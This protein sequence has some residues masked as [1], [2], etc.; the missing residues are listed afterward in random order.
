MKMSNLSIN[1]NAFDFID[2]EAVHFTEQDLTKEQKAQVRKNIDAI[3]MTYSPPANLPSGNWDGFTYGNGM[4]IAVGYKVS[5]GVTGC[6]AYSY[7]G[8][9]WYEAVL[10]RV[11]SSGGLNSVVYA[12]GKFVAVGTM[13]HGAYSIDGE[14]WTVTETG[15]VEDHWEKIAYGNGKY[16]AV[17]SEGYMICSNDGITWDE[18]IQPFE[19]TI[20]R[21]ITFGNGVFVA[22]RYSSGSS[23]TVYSVDGINWDLCN[24]N[25][26]A[27]YVTYT[28]DRFIASSFGDIYYS[29]DGINWTQG[30]SVGVDVDPQ[31]VYFNGKYVA[32]GV[33]QMRGD[34]FSYISDDLNT[35]TETNIDD[36]IG[37]YHLLSTENS[38]IAISEDSKLLFSSNGID[39]SIANVVFTKGNENIT[40]DMKSA[41]GICY[42]TVEL[43]TGDF[44]IDGKP[45]YRKT[46]ELPEIA[47]NRTSTDVLITVSTDCETIIRAEG[48]VNNGSGVYYPINF[49]NLSSSGYK[50]SMWFKSGGIAIQTGTSIEIAGGFVTVYYTKTV[51]SA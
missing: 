51:T 39:W 33:S 31:I 17:N 10:D 38:L 34:G 24:T 4:Y 40:E 49:A 13:G 37:W 36:S 42:N 41:M 15:E 5:G 22:V 23:P 47:A 9:E 45:I 14:N 28:G 30:G 6:A 2:D 25:F 46:I 26:S 35:W 48:M 7:N 43:K 8:S 19:N 50:V 29:T 18:K 16:V 12:N 3:S 1:Q 44:W 11:M 20:W 32:V 21:D 27:L